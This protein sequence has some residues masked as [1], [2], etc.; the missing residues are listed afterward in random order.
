MR[1]LA[2]SLPRVDQEVFG[3]LDFF[4]L[5]RSMW[6]EI[7]S[8]GSDAIA[9]EMVSLV[10]AWSFHLQSIRIQVD[11]WWGEWDRFSSPVVGQR[12]SAMIPDSR[13]RLEATAGHLILF[14]HWQAI[15][16][17]LIGA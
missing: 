9:D 14:T 7:R 16:E 2:A 11:I 17:S 5:R 6:E 15:L 4:T 1:E 3:N 8:N 10:K 12:M 13:L